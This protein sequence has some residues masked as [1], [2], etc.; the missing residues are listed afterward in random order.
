MRYL[1]LSLLSASMY[2]AVENLTITQLERRSF[3]APQAMGDVNLYHSDLG[4]ALDRSGWT[5]ALQNHQLDSTLR[6]MTKEQL[7]SFLDVGYIKVKELEDGTIE[8]ESRVR[9]PGGVKFGGSFSFNGPGA[10]GNSWAGSLVDAALS[11]F[12]DSAKSTVKDA[13]IDSAANQ[14]IPSGNGC[15][16][17][18]PD[19]NRSVMRNNKEYEQA[20]QKYPRMSE[21][22]FYNE[23]ERRADILKATS[24]GTPAQQSE[25]NQKLKEAGE[26]AKA[27]AERR[28]QHEHAAQIAADKERVRAAQVTAIVHKQAAQ[29]LDRGMVSLPKENKPVITVTS[30]SKNSMTIA[31]SGDKKSQ[32]QFT[33]LCRDTTIGRDTILTTPSN[34]IPVDGDRVKP[35]PTPAAQPASYKAPEKVSEPI[36]VTGPMVSLIEIPESPDRPEQ[37]L[38]RPK[39]YTSTIQTPQDFTDSSLTHIL[40]GN[41]FHTVPG[42]TDHMRGMNLSPAQTDRQRMDNINTARVVGKYAANAVVIKGMAETALNLTTPQGVVSEIT[43]YTVSN[44]VLNDPVITFGA[45]VAMGY[46]WPMAALFAGG[47]YLSNLI[48]KSSDN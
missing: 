19:A 2:A 7:E 33:A 21:E 5:T 47:S 42:V 18:N 44:Y 20:R 3:F 28:Y 40:R 10:A 32:D 36:T 29:S 11:A 35:L 4:F 37:S 12:A 45:S 48:R 39:R 43:K 46:S 31:V 27:A 23:R 16:T 34:G 24:L 26:Q 13:V 1:A 8:L 41:I 14:N 6:G 38:E 15:G 25:I 17:P 9:G 22:E 30:E